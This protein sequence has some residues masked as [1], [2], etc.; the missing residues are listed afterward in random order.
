MTPIFFLSGAPAVG[1][2]TT[3]RA[4][5]ARFPKSIHISVDD[6]RTMVVSGLVLPGEWVPS[7]VEQLRLARQSASWMAKIYRAA[8][9]TV[10]IDDFWDP[11]S[12]LEE[13]S[14]LFQE[15]DVH[16]ILLYPSQQAAE[17]RSL[18]RAGPGE[19]DEYIASGIRVVYEHLG[20]EIANLARQG[21]QVLDTSGQ[22][23]EETVEGLLKKISA[24][25]VSTLL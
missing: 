24:P 21:W 6:I 16:K 12:R 2:S 13:Y 20:T 10:V 23:I 1:K 3:A 5:A 14:E 17:A 15:P 7:L 22:T 8:G 25:A 19:S 11:S 4:L 18:K 9:F